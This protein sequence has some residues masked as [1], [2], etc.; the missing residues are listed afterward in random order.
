MILQDYHQYRAERLKFESQSHLFID[1]APWKLCTALHTRDISLSGISGW[2]NIARL[3]RIYG[4]VPMSRVLVPGAKFKIQ[5]NHRIESLPDYIV[6]ATVSRQYKA[7]DGSFNVAFRF[8][9]ATSDIA[10]LID[11]IARH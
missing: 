5:L 10:Y 9:Q 8:A 1:L 6:D 4:Q 3:E 7:A 11:H 2:L